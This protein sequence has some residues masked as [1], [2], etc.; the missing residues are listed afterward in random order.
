MEIK[1]VDVKNTKKIDDSVIGIAGIVKVMPAEFYKNTTVEQ[2]AMFGH[3][4][5]LYGFLTN[6][7][8]QW[9]LQRIE[10][11]TTIEIGAGSG[12][13]GGR[14]SSATGTAPDRPEPR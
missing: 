1:I 2:R 12:L 7:L 14:S 11:R 4:H 10:D 3:Q 5:S 8:R 13:L 6:E 9:L